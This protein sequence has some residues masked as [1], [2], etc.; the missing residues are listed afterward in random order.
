MRLRIV[1]AIGKV[2]LRMLE[3]TYRENEYRLDNLCGRK[4]EHVQVV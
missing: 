1:V 2:A 4:G 3:N